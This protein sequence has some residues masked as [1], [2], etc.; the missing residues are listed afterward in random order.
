MMDSQGVIIASTD[1]TRMG[2]VHAGALRLLVENLSELV[3]QSNDEY[4]GARKGLNL[5]VSIDGEVQGVIGVTGEYD[6]VVRY[7]HVLQTMTEILLRE[8]RDKQVKK[9]ADR[10]RDRFLDEWILEGAP[11]TQG[12]IDRGLRLGVEASRHYWVAVA[13]LA[14]LSTFS[15]SEAGQAL[16][17]SVNRLVRA[18][19]GKAPCGVFSKTPN[20]M[21]CLFATD[22]V[23]FAVATNHMQHIAA[24]VAERFDRRIVVGIGEDTSD[25]HRGFIQAD[26]ALQAALHSGQP[27][28]HYAD[29]AFELIVDEISPLA[30]QTFIERVF[31]SLSESDIAWWVAVLQ[32]YYDCEGSLTRASEQLFIH[33]NTLNAALN[34]LHVLTGLDPR[35][36]SGGALFWL[37]VQLY[38]RSQREAS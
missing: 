27:L 28:M 36:R 37:A 18:E 17:D 25:V 12:F 20:R 4:P 14:G 33:K 16:I 2:T 6:E 34:R 32:A 29:V 5:P 11:L 21:I 7:G 35:S 30:Q 23:P 13:Q 8:N 3:V 9:V 31:R 19:V 26:K 24:V 10:I 38:Q 22:Y 15:H 1:P